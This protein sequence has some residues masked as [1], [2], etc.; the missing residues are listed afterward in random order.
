[1]RRDISLSDPTY[2]TRPSPSAWEKFAQRF[3]CDV[4]DLPFLR[5]SLAMTFVLLPLAFLLYWPG[6]FRW[7]MAPV[8]WAVLFGL[9]FDRYILMLH[10]TSHR[11]LF[12]REWNWLNR[13]IP[14]VLGPFCG[15]TPETYFIHHITMHHAEGNMPGDLSSTMKYQRDRL[16]HFLHYFFRFFFLITF[17]MARYQL[18]R[19][20][21]QIVRR[22]LVGELGFYAVCILLAFLNW[23][24]T[25]VVFVVPFLLCRFL[26]MA[27]NWG[28]HAFVDASDP[29]NP[30]KSAITCIN[31]RYNRRCFNDGYHIGHHVMANRHW[32]E[33]PGEFAANLDTYRDEDAIV[34]E[35]VD[36]FIVWGLLMLGRY[37]VLAR[38]FVDLRDEPR[39]AAEIEAL[40]RTRT[41][42]FSPAQLA[43]F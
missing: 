36:F 40:L 32:T 6:V 42:R 13:Y 15:E 29:R 31:A 21:K 12:R 28:Q 9:F 18:G 35:G 22:M 16:S 24:A 34:F 19:G 43:A 38:R 26:M 10:N 3:V 41:Q 30:Y 37:D 25:L 4:R 33:H 8:Y 23:Q 39:S 14:W 2:T 1:M 17:D 27:G 7:W 5:L 20:R 11:R